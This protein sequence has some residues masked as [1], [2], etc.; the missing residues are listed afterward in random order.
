M[1]FYPN[2]AEPVWSQY[3]THSVVHTMEVYSR[4]SFDYPYPTAQSVN[5]KRGGMEY[6]MITN[7]YRPDP[8]GPA[9]EPESAS[10]AGAGLFA[11]SPVWADRGDHPR[12]GAH[13]LPDD[14]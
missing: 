4:F 10:R 8:P 1:S 3:S 2:E 14:R 13:L 11:A 6:P 7:G 12:D 5:L 9:E